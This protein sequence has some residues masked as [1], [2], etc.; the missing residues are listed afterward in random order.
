MRNVVAA[1]TF[2]LALPAAIG[3]GT[4]PAA[5]VQV[6]SASQPSCEAKPSIVV[7]MRHAEKASEDG[8]PELS[9]KGQERAKRVATLLGA[10]G[11]TQLFATEVKRTQQ[12]LAPLA[13]RTHQKVQVRQARQSA[14]L[15]AE[16]RALPPGSVAV[17]AHHSNGVPGLAKALGVEINGVHEGAIAHDAFGRVFVIASG[18]GARPASYIE[19]SSD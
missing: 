14:A 3:C 15:A 9:D 8:D 7:L 19:L 18:C 10:A 16:L 17:V 11:A 13:E 2:L 12:T 5:P 6:A 4:T 1:L